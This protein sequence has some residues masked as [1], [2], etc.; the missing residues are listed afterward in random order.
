MFSF[1]VLKLEIGVLDQDLKLKDFLLNQSKEKVLIENNSNMKIISN[2][3]IDESFPCFDYS[4][5]S[6]SEKD[7]PLLKKHKGYGCKDIKIRLLGIIL[8]RITY[9]E[10]TP[11]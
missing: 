5:Y 2:I 1:K 4:Q 9:I 3:K 8:I 7:Y 10:T 11:F 6:L